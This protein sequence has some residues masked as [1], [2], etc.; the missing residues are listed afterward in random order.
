MVVTIQA[1]AAGLGALILA[2]FNGSG[3][4]AIE[5]VNFFQNPGRVWLPIP[6]LIPITF[7]CYKKRASGGGQLRERERAEKDVG[8][9]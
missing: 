3:E 7:F 6:D 2:V 8:R 9:R 4:Q 1:G 5:H